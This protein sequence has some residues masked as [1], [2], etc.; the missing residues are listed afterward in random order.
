MS[1]LFVPC[2]SAEPQSSYWWSGF[3]MVLVWNTLTFTYHLGLFVHEEVIITRNRQFFPMSCLC[4]SQIHSRSSCSEVRSCGKP[5]LLSIN[6][7]SCMDPICRLRCHFRN[8]SSMLLLHSENFVNLNVVSLQNDSP[9]LSNKHLFCI[10]ESSRTFPQ[11]YD[12][13]WQADFKSDV[14]KR[15][16]EESALDLS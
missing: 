7:C 13:S 8:W 5:D 6:S 1:E 14:L 11:D 3:S 10:L 4:F 12:L 9:L 16:S 2:L 15:T